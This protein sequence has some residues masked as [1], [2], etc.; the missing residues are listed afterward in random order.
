MPRMARFGNT[1][2]G[3]KT[4]CLFVLPNGFLF[5]V[6]VPTESP[7]QIGGLGRSH[8]ISIPVMSRIMCAHLV[9]YKLCDCQ[10]TVWMQGA[11]CNQVQI[12]ASGRWSRF[13]REM[14]I[15]EQLIHQFR[16]VLHLGQWKKLRSPLVQ[17]WLE[18]SFAVCGVLVPLCFISWTFLKAQQLPRP[19][20]TAGIPPRIKTFQLQKYQTIYWTQLVKVMPL[21]EK[22]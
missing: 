6:A 19:G 3:C 9:S 8:L 7:V 10:R 5:I 1:H 13:E 17:P 4:V 11:E 16:N 2:A 21:L 22:P 20:T 15:N 18:A 12:R 14:V